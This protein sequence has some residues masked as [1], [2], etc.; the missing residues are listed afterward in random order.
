MGKPGGCFATTH[1]LKHGEPLSLLSLTLVIDAFNR[2]HPGGFHGGRQEVVMCHWRMIL[3][4]C[5]RAIWKVLQ[6]LILL[7]VLE[8]LLGLKI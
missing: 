8:L 5:Y 2:M 6:V 1:D 3:L 4:T 7:D